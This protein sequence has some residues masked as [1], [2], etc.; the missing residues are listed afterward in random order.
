MPDPMAVRRQ[1]NKQNMP[2]RYKLESDSISSEDRIFTA[3]R[4]ILVATRVMTRLD[5]ST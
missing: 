4:V 1:K 2:L 3:G 5:L